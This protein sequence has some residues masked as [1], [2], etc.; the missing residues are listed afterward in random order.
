MKNLAPS[1]RT[2]RILKQPSSVYSA[3]ET[4]TCQNKNVNKDVITINDD[5]KFDS[6]KTFCDLF[7]FI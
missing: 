3:V 4:E 2:E 1:N 7:R 5:T 6:E